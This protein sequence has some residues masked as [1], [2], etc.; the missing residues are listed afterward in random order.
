M[1]YLTFAD[2]LK[3]ARRLRQW[4]QACLSQCTGIPT[5][6]LSALETERRYPTE[7]EWGKLQQCLSLG[8]YQ[9]AVELPVAPRRYHAAAPSR[10]RAE[11]TFAQRFGAARNQFGRLPDLLMAEINQ[12]EDAAVC[13]KLLQD[14]R[15]DSGVEALLWMRLLAEG[16]H[17]CCFSPLRAGFRR[18][19]V[20]H[21][22]SR[23]CIGD[24]RLPCLT[25]ETGSWF[26]M[27]F[28][29]VTLDA[30]RACYRLDALMGLW[31]GKRGV[32]LNLEVDGEGHRSDFD[33]QRQKDLGLEAV[34]LSQGDLRDSE[35]L[36][37]LALRCA[38]LLARERTA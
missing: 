22:G 18:L 3:S 25:L 19:P 7:Q 17:P 28:P 8:P 36:P 20:V 13:L 1:S 2:R 23:E 14:A 5:S 31:A 27:L 38:P 29:Q 37:L 16:G 30:R 26:A 6:R 15:L 21:G 12:R 10:E 9:P 32:W 35:V 4:T 34:R 24:M 11:R 33:R